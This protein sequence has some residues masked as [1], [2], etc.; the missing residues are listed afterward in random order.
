[1]PFGLSTA[2]KGASG[3]DLNL[4]GDLSIRKNTTIIRKLLENLDQPTAGLTVISIKIAADYI[5]NERF[6]VRLFFDRI[7]NTPVISTS[8]PTANTAFGVSVRFT[9]A[10]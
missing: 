1:M 2:K 10:Q 8:F 4:T 5:I 9:L 7:V 6:N 3:N